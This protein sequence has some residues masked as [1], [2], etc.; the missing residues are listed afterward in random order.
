MKALVIHVDGS[1]TREDPKTLEDLQALVSGDIEAIRFT[2]EMTAYVNEN[3]ISLNLPRNQRATAMCVDYCVGVHPDDFI[4]GAMVLVGA[5]D[6]EGNDTDVPQYF[7]DKLLEPPGPPTPLVI[8][9]TEAVY[10]NAKKLVQA[11]KAWAYKNDQMPEE[12]IEQILNTILGNQLVDAELEEN[13]IIGLAKDFGAET[14][15]AQHDINE[16]EETD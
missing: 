7:V 5:T 16:P 4:K 8:D 11:A 2:S 9:L 14:T 6:A 1:V 10:V 15:N 3:G 13:I 12:T